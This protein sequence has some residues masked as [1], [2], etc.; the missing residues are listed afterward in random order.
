[1]LK[2]F[3]TIEDM[4]VAIDADKNV[5]GINAG[6]AN[7]FPVRFV[8]FDNFR[9]SYEFISKMSD[10]DIEI[11]SVDKWMNPQ[12]DDMFI[13]RIE[14]ANNIE[15]YIEDIKGKDC[16]VAPFSELA[17]FYDNI[18]HK[19][20]DA[21]I[22]KLKSIQSTNTAFDKHQR[23]YIV[24][25]GQYSKISNFENDPQMFAWY[26]KSDGKQFNYRLVLSNGTDYDVRNLKSKYTVVK[27]L[28]EWLYLWRNGMDITNTIIST[29]PSIYAYEQ[30]ALPDNAFDFDK[31]ENVYKFLTLG[32]KLSFGN[33]QYKECDDEH[34]RELAEK[35]DVTNFSFSKFIKQY[36]HLFELKDY[37]DF[38]KAWHNIDDAFDKWLLVT[39]YLSEFDKVDYLFSALQNCRTY[40]DRELFEQLMLSIFDFEDMSAIYDIRID[41]LRLLKH[42]GAL[43]K[44][45]QETL[46]AELV[47]VAINYGYK[48]A[49][50][51]LTPFTSVEKEIAIK[52]YGE[53]NLAICDLRANFPMFYCYLQNNV[54]PIDS[55]EW[56]ESYIE[57]YKKA[58]FSN[59]Y[60]RSV[61]D[62]L[63]VH[64]AN[65]V[66]FNS[67]YQDFKTVRT[68]LADRDDID[69]F[70][71][72]DGL[73]VDWIPVVRSIVE[74]EKQNGIYLNEVII[75]KS[76]LPT[77]TSINKADLEKL[78]PDKLVKIGDLDNL[79]HKTNNRYPEYILEEFDIMANAIRTIIDE[80]AGKKI[81]IVS[82]HGLTH[83]SQHCS[84]LNLAG[85]ESDHHGRL[86]KKNS[87]ILPDNKYVVVNG[88]TVCALEHSSLCSKVPVG[89]AAHGGATPEEVLVPIFI[90]SDQESV[91]SWTVKLLTKELPA[92]TPMIRF[93]I[94]GLKDETPCVVYNSNPYKLSK[95]ADNEYQSAR[96]ELVQNVEDIVLCI[97]T[98]KQ[99]YH[100]DINF[101]AE[102]EDLF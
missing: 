75:G 39:Y 23:I 36:F 63:L 34:W 61:G 42:R 22:T 44:E 101:G 46:E 85:F 98:T 78:T 17:R 99:K 74:A 72:I 19:E 14:L 90:I 50:N 54:L 24:I 16:V 67:W 48:T 35:I 79:A 87:G 30:N 15:N 52:W 12:Y 65:D 97:G 96:I 3:G 25:V 51:L 100:I 55:Q 11:Q 45:A 40:T 10:K 88:N 38:I 89:Q 21:L 58:K 53:G 94:K 92:T 95:V 57:K 18:E 71:W 31:C 86:A 8:L 49:V 43:S 2:S 84:G 69:V 77:V 1:M 82:D 28:K 32:L 29:S 80:Y 41:I 7:R 6:T 33:V 70:Y 68:I 73:G 27:N 20:F 9:D 56:I 66:A 5:T 59:K 47:K 93:E 81:A 4:L 64:S 102:E 83:L 91:Q 60:D 26:L 76:L 62:A 13:S 37:R